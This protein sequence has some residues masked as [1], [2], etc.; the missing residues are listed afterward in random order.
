MDE[1]TLQIRRAMLAAC[2]IADRPGSGSQSLVERA[3]SRDRDISGRFAALNARSRR[4]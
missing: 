4:S 2:G 1:R 3:R